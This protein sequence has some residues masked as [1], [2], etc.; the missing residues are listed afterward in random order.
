MKRISLIVSCFVLLLTSSPLEG[1]SILV[2]KVTMYKPLSADDWVNTKPDPATDVSA[3]A[4]GASTDPAPLDPKA[5][6]GQVLVYSRG[7]AG[8]TSKLP[9]VYVSGCKAKVGAEF[10]TVEDH[11]SA[12]GSIYVKGFATVNIN[13]MLYHYNLPPK[14]LTSGQ[15][16]VTDFNEEFPKDMV[17]CHENFNIKWFYTLSAEVANNPYSSSITWLDAGESD[18]F[19][20]VTY[21]KP[22]SGKL[23]KLE[24][25][26]T[27][28]LTPIYLACKVAHGFQ[29]TDSE[30][31]IALFFD[32]FRDN[33]V[34]KH[35]S[36]VDLQY[37]GGRNPLISVPYCRSIA[38]LLRY[39]DANCG[40]WASFFQDILKT[41]GIDKGRV[42][43]LHW[44]DNISGLGVLDTTTQKHFYADIVSAFGAGYKS[45]VGIP[46]IGATERV[47]A[48]FFVKNH[49][50]TAGT[51]KFYLYNEEHY[52]ECSAPATTSS[53]STPLGVVL[54]S[55]NTSGIS[56]QG[57]DDPRSYFENHAMIRI[58]KDEGEGSK[59]VLDPSYGVPSNPATTLSENS[60]EDAA[61]KGYG[62]W[63]FFKPVDDD[64]TYIIFWV[65]EL[66]TSEKQ[67]KFTT[68]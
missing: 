12:G 35:N 62:V 63:F 45:T 52:S 43:G 68:E 26:T 31:L 11:C 64:K 21:Q 20:M 61:I 49:S 48:S 14:A 58:K 2:Q 25:S 13:G 50:F 34:Q 66:N 29:S 53:I 36:S 54:T 19:V 46:V 60:Y 33:K 38:G 55:C 16:P 15:Y 56:A 5:L 17:Q 37:W 59:Y 22:I 44:Q 67:L 40:E 1:Q 30:D 3:S 7:S 28:F 23:G 27:F 47:V 18:C 8:N 51:R 41:Q 6:S 4:C 57:N 42:L 65:F 24:E 39:R 10:L 32:E 9:A